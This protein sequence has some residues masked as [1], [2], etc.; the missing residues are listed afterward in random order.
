MWSLERTNM[1]VNTVPGVWLVAAHKYYSAKTVNTDKVLIV[2][3][4]SGSDVTSLPH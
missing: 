1:P 4:L 3:E 2:L